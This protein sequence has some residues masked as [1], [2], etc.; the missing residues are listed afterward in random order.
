MGKIYSAGSIAV[1]TLDTGISLCAI[2][3]NGNYTTFEKPVGTPHQVPAGELLTIGLVIF[4]S[5][6]ARGSIEIGYGDSTVDDS[7]T[8][9]TNYVSLVKELPVQTADAINEVKAFIKIPS[10]KYPCI[11]ALTAEGNC[12]ILGIQEE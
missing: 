2:A 5:A 11:R 9:P 4:S 1:D 6:I 3:S 12:I 8:P 7:G 10:E